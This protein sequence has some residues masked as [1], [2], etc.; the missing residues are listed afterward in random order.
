MSNTTSC[1]QCF[2]IIIIITTTTTTT[3]T[4]HD[5]YAVYLQLYSLPEKIYCL[6]PYTIVTISNT[7]RW[8]HILLTC[9]VNK[10]EV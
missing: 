9:R 6:Y 3:T 8:T 1:R 2:Y 10:V 4:L 7:D 5:L